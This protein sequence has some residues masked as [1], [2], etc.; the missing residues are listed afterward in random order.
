[1][2]TRRRFLE[3]SLQCAALLAGAS[4]WP[5]LSFAAAGTEDS[6]RFIVVL[7]RGA[8][9]GLSAVPP[10]AD[11]AYASSRGPIAI[12]APG[13]AGGALDLDGF[14]GVHPSLA[15]LHARYRDRELLVIHAVATPYRDRSHFDGQNVLENGGDRPSGSA[16]GWLNRALAVL[17]QQPSNTQTGLAI[18]QNVPL[19]LRGAVPVGSWAPARLPD[20]EPDLITRLRDLYSS[21]A[22]L[23]A[24]LDEAV[25]IDA[26]AGSGP[27][28]AG[29]GAPVMRGA[30][31]NLA[32]AKQMAS[33]AG[34]M[35]ASPAGP[36][37]AVLDMTGWDTHAGE[38]AAEGALGSRLRGLDGVLDSLRAGLGA[39]WA[40]SAVMVCTEF[41]RTVMV[42]GT[43]GTDHG[44]AA[45]AFLLGGAVNGGRMLVDW[46]GLGARDL[47]EGRDLRA[48]VDL[49]AIAKGVLHDHLGVSRRGLD[50]VFPGSGSLAPAMDL[51]RSTPA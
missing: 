35:I 23:A 3:S 44:T 50:Q 15:S 2:T 9:D 10:Y 1:M 24:R 17:P 18:G 8:L 43:R 16:N 21:D 40:R 25:A 26:L 32:L 22:T 34:R 33:T 7:L 12:A 14:F 27:N 48:T 29:G 11:A 36:R 37:I 28:G 47:Y 31:G 46:P 20:V 39:Q 5:R 19:I 6:A 45:A 13:A 30:S 51:I 49:R 42:N 4:A 38:G 41:G